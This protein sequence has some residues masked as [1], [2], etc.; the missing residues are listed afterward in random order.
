MCS[1]NHISMAGVMSSASLSY[2]MVTSIIEIYTSFTFISVAGTSA[3][4]DQLDD[5]I[6][7]FTKVLCRSNGISMVGASQIKPASVDTSTIYTR[8]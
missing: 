2:G 4:H 7:C 8:W 3:L 5:I 1:Q 6:I